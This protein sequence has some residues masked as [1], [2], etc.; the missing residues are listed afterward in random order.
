M[1]NISQFF[2]RQ[3]L[4]YLTYLPRVFFVLKRPVAFLQSYISG[5]LAIRQLELKNWFVYDLENFDDLWVFYEIFIKREYGHIP[6]GKVTIVDIG[7]NNGLFMLYCKA[8]NADATLHCYEPVP[9]C[10]KHIGETVYE[11][12]L[13]NVFVHQKAVSSSRG[14]QKLFLGSLTIAAS[15]YE[16]IASTDNAISVETDTL[17]HIFTDNAISSIDYLKV[18][19][20]GGEYDIF[21]TAPA[22]LLEKCKH[23]MIEYHD[24][25]DLKNGRQLYKHLKAK[26]PQRKVLFHVHPAH[27]HNGFISVK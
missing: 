15:L 2:T 26:L 13:S 12:N 17:E 23:M 10:A 21:Y 14:E 25:D 3:T 6:H 9:S 19:C 24:I 20:E 11:N 27:P 18:D 16:N 4:S 1:R 8:K 5:R 22:E 7:A